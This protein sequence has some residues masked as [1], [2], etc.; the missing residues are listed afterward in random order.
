MV[1]EAVVVK[2][3]ECKLCESVILLSKLLVIIMPEVLTTVVTVSSF[4][5]VVSGSFED[6]SWDVVNVKSVVNNDSVDSYSFGEDDDRSRSIDVEDVS[7]VLW[8][9]MSEEEDDD[10]SM[11]SSVAIVDSRK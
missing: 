6:N 4:E 1:K 11:Y 10:V 2:E 3:D 5:G 7:V 9:S 8:I